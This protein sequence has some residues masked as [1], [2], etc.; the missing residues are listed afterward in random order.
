MLNASILI[1]RAKALERTGSDA[2]LCRRI[3]FRETQLFSLQL[4]QL[5]INKNDYLS[6]HIFRTT[7][8]SRMK[9]ETLRDI[10]YISYCHFI[11]IK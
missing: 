3:T 8:N 6:K 4:L 1:I 11:T 9:N 2:R 10:T 7:Y 5:A